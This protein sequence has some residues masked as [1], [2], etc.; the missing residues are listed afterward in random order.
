MRGLIAALLLLASPAFAGEFVLGV[1]GVEQQLFSWVFDP[2]AGTVNSDYNTSECLKLFGTTTTKIDAEVACS[3]DSF[4]AFTLPRDVVLTRLAV[5]RQT[6]IDDGTSGSD[7]GGCD[8]ILATS[9]GATEIAAS[10]LESPAAD[11]DV[12]VGTISSVSF[13]HRVTAG[14][15]VNILHKNGSH[16][17]DGTGCECD[18]EWG[19]NTLSVFGVL[20]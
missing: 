18:A 17:G 11:G 6:A 15:M 16:C 5:V 13:Q 14:T 2:G 10:E 9:D 8:F 12:A 3:D 20:Q 19:D 1:N 4:G 7:E